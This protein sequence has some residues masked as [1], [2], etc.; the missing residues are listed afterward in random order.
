[1]PSL[2]N[3]PEELTA[4]NG[5]SSTLESLAFFVGPALGALLLGVADVQVVFLLNAGTFLWSRLSCSAFVSQ[6]PRRP[7]HVPAEDEPKASFLTE[8]LAGFQHDPA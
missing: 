3:R 5:T 4:S 8:T 1:M 6:R 7:A 2:A